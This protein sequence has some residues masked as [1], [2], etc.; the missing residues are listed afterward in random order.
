MLEFLNQVFSAS[1]GP[2]SMILNVSVYAAMII[3]FIIMVFKC[4]M[5]LVSSRRALKRA[6]RLM[7]RESE[8]RGGARKAWES[9]LLLGDGFLRPHWRAYLNNAFFCENHYQTAC[10]VEDYINETTVI[11]VPS[12]AYLAEMTPSMLTSLGFLGTLI[13]I[14]YGLLGMDLMGSTENIIT[15][16]LSLLGGMKYAF[17]TS[18]VGVVGSIVFNLVVKYN[19]GATR[20][21]LDDFIE[22]FR[23]NDTSPSVDPLTQIACYQQEQTL[24]MRAI[25]E[26]VTLKFVERLDGVLAANLN[27]VQAALDEF[28]HTVTRHQ[29]DGVDRIVSAFVERLNASLKGQFTALGD[30][31]YQTCQWQKQ[32]RDTM[33]HA[34]SGVASAARDIASVQEISAG[35]IAQFEKYIASLAQAQG[36]ADA[37]YEAIARQ[38]EN[39]Q[40]I[41]N[42]QSGYIE[43]LSGYQASV[44]GALEKY[45]A[46]SEQWMKLTNET[47]Q[48]GNETLKKLAE[49]LTVSANALKEAYQSFETN[50]AEGLERTLNVFDENMVSVTRQLGEVI[51]GIKESV[52]DLPGLIDRPVRE[53]SENMSSLTGALGEFREEITYQT[54]KLTGRPP[55]TRRE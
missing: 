43:K 16:M 11:D 23:Q 37:G 7:E 51:A 49:E 34:L 32:A 1:Q 48:S 41:A 24:H 50:I 15:S 31:I 28:M 30:T 6:L 29:V 8:T 12:K 26:E 14:M 46:I 55:V 9:E 47:G 27:P 13:G 38:V 36:K 42:A 20:V 54:Q 3:V 40:S 25:V 53:I 45:T 18:I 19:T 2:L 4:T 5:P 10:D 35:I 44:G 17:G 21:A 52:E 22:E 39:M 33:E